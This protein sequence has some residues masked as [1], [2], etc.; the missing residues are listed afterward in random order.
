MGKVTQVCV[1]CGGAGHTP[2]KLAPSNL[3]ILKVMAAGKWY[4]SNDVPGKNLTMRSMALARLFELGLVER[5]EQI[6][7]TGRFYQSRIT[8]KGLQ[9]LSEGVEVW[10]AR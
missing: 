9:L 5:E 8:A 3:L 4:T 2:I 10:H 1:H 6:D 7:Q